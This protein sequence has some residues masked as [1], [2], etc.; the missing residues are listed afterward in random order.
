MVRRSA[1][2]ASAI[3]RAQCSRVPRP[4]R[5]GQRGR[6]RHPE[7]VRIPVGGHVGVRRRQRRP[8]LRRRGR[9]WRRRRA[10]GARRARRS[11]CGGRRPPPPPARPG[12]CRPRCG[13]GSRK[14]GRR[15]AGQGGDLRRRGLEP[16]L[17]LQPGREAERALVERAGDPPRHRPHLGRPARRRASPIT[18]RRTAAWPTRAATFSAAGAA[19]RRSR[20]APTGYGPAPSTPTTAVVIPCA[21]CE[22]AGS[23]KTWRST[24]LC[25]SMK[26][27]ATTRPVTS[28]TRSLGRHREARADLD[29][30]VAADAHVGGARRGPRPVD[31]P[32]AAQHER[33]LRRGLERGAAAART[34]P[35]AG[36]PRGGGSTAPRRG[37]ARAG[38]RRRRGRPRAGQRAQERGHVDGAVAQELAHL[39]RVLGDELR[40]GWTAGG[41]RRSASAAAPGR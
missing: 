28:I 26:P 35:R 27:G 40:A 1:P 22:A 18:A 23:A 7:G 25:R 6:G 30:A 8:A 19:A 38:G 32:A 41:A 3:T 33:R 13:R 14:G 10:S 17:V 2:P 9:G 36:P 31:D 15:L 29:D 5:G 37:R 39:A 34:R 24:W 21:V 4:A 20:K 12:R 16:G 11:P